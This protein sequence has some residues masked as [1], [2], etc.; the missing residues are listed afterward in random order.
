MKLGKLEYNGDLDGWHNTE[1]EF[2]DNDLFP[3]NEAAPPQEIGVEKKEKRKRKKKK[4]LLPLLSKEKPKLNKKHLTRSYHKCC[5]FKD[6][7]TV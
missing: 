4:N 3:S 2:E 5:L 1:D 7:S 6:S